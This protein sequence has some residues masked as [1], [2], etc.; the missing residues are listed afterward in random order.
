M[1]KLEEIINRIQEQL[2]GDLPGLSAHRKALPP[3]RDPGT[4]YEFDK[5]SNPRKSGVLIMLFE[6]EKGEVRFPLMERPSYGG[7]HSGQVSLPGGRL[8][9]QDNSLID[10]ALRETAEEI[11]VTGVE[12]VGELSQLYIPPSNFL[13]TP[14]VGYYQ[15]MPVF[16]KEPREVEE[17]FTVGLDEL[18]D[19]S[20]LK[21]TDL[22][23]R[24][25]VFRNI[26]YFDFADRI[27]W[28]A[29][30]MILCEFAELLQHD[31]C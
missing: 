27:V 16:R 7:V 30:A 4:R 25:Q 8:E 13:V 9:K 6:D 28:G 23:V 2:K 15:G 18:L 31:Q 5:L 12:V 10:T 26:P 14:V 24:G 11:G 22:E 19:E 29:T 3:D 17:I 1:Q 21:H 20:R